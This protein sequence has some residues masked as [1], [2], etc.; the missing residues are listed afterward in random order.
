[1]NTR[2]LLVHALS[3]VHCGTGQSIGGIDLP[4]AREKPTGIPLIPGS[5][6]KGVLRANKPTNEKEKL[7]LAVFGPDTVNA[8]DNAGSIQLSDANLVFLPVRSIR[9]TFAWVTSPY[10][11]RRLAR[12]ARECGIDFGA[13]PPEPTERE[14]LVTGDRLAAKDQVIFEDLDFTAR[15]SDTLSKLVE[16]FAERLFDEVDRAHFVERACV[17]HDDVMSLLLQ[18]S[19][20]ITT[21]IR[22]DPDRKTVDGGAL[23]SE[24]ALPVESVL[25]GLVVA[26]PVMQKDK[27]VPEAGAMLDYVKGLA[28]RGAMQIGGKATVGRGLCRIRLAKKEG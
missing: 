17:V 11:L 19:T 3:P 12:D 14:A 1:M 27:T 8:S 24:E 26:A 10:I 28:E 5:S 9:G 4:I 21:R 7:H 16:A 15:R 25:A 2:L 23:W 6:I 18:T 22:L 20:E 13:L